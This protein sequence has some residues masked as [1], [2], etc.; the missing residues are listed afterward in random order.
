M[1]F[2][3][4]LS[5]LLLIA[6]YPFLFLQFLEQEFR[7]KQVWAGVDDIVLVLVCVVASA[8]VIMILNAMLSKL[9]PSLF[10]LVMGIVAV[11]M[12]FWPNYTRVVE[13]TVNMVAFI[14]LIMVPAI[15]GQI[16][17]VFRPR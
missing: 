4:P 3:R 1:R 12:I 2:L 10:G 13:T 9:P 14:M 5:G 6:A 11:G 15:L 17:K 7:I 8:L 16:F